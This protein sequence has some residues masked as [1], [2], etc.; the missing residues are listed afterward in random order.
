MRGA[1]IALVVVGTILGLLGFGVAAA[2]GVMLWADA[3][4]D[5]DGYITSPTYT[6]AVDSYAVTGERIDLGARPG[7][8]EWVPWIGE[9]GVRLEVAAETEKP[10]FVG[11][12]PDHAVRR[13][14]QGVHHHQLTR[15][16]GGADRVEYLAAPGSGSPPAPGTQTF[17]T[18]STEG[19]GV[20][21]LTWDAEP[22]RWAMVIM[23]AD[24][25][26][27]I[28]VSTTAGATASFIFPL[29]LGLLIGG[30]V[31]LA[32]AVV[33]VVVGILGTARSAGSAPGAPAPTPRAGTYPL[34]LTGR[35]DD[36]LN[37]GLWLVKWLLAVP[38]FVV[39]AFLWAAFLFLT[40]AAGIA[41]LFTG[42][43]PRAMFEFNAG[44]LRWSWRVSYYAHGV[45]GTDTYPPFTLAATDY[46]ADL[47]IAY[48]EQLSRG[49]VLVKWWLLAIPHYLVL[50]VLTGGAYTVGSA[51]TQQEGGWELTAGGGLIGVLVLIAAVALLFTGRYPGGLFDVVMGL[52]RWVY[53]VIAYAALMTDEYPPFRLDTGGDDPGA[54]PPAPAGGPPAD[55]G[56]AQP[57]VHT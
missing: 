30:L 36:R 37:R 44:V 20:Q 29:G 42:R 32:T 5:A 23:N 11:I 45:L 57:L 35:L 17:W 1:R 41:I 4:R 43:Y 3:A 55:E 48:P 14:L 24:G 9:L 7:P 16:D 46:P 28:A 27:G 15:L 13:Y 6:L 56:A 50:A 33:L 51:A 21:T 53:R 54:G 47:Q 40:M 39:L 8:G 22:G 10:V 34:T 12:G 49:L 26:P 25:S 38:H 19:S 31:A 18:A 52:Q 2:G